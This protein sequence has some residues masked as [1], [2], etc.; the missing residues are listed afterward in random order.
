VAFSLDSQLLASGAYDETV[1]LWDTATGSLQQ[2]LNTAGIATELHFSQDG[3]YLDTNLGLLNIQARCGEITSS[4]PKANPEIFVN[5]NWIVLNGRQ[6]L[7]LPPEARAACSAVK[8][9]ILALGLESG[10][11]YFIGFQVD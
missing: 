3:S 5:G 7:W 8:S 2:T 1:R 4:V 10:R 6:V 9:I 11:V